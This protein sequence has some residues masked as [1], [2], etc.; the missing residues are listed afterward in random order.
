M[1]YC[2][3]FICISLMTGGM[4]HFIHSFFFD[5]I[6][7]SL[8]SEL[9][10]EIETLKALLKWRQWH[11]NLLSVLYILSK[12]HFH[13][14]LKDSFLIHMFCAYIL[15]L[16]SICL[17]KYTHIHTH[18]NTRKHVHVCVC[19]CLCL[20]KSVHQRLSDKTSGLA[21][22]EGSSKMERAWAGRGSTAS[23]AAT[24]GP[25]PCCCS[26]MLHWLHWA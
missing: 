6:L 14:Y 13:F 4:K 9:I 25:L 3:V 23:N 16:R 11:K 17:H 8:I 12:H 10:D 20:S 7:L 2:V 21:S 1:E 15:N 19:L 18:T 26:K 5:S 22:L 24:L